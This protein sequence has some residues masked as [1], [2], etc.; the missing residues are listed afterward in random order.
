MQTVMCVQKHPTRTERHP[1]RE[2]ETTCERVG[3]LH[4]LLIPC[5]CAAFHYLLQVK[6]A[7]WRP[8]WLEEFCPV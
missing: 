7:W 4:F 5:L 1:V 2:Q 8:V 6:K 3:E